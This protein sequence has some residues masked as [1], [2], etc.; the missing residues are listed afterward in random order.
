MTAEEII[1]GALE[2]GDVGRWD[3]RFP[4]NWRKWI[5]DDA[6]RRIAEALREAGLL[7]PANPAPGVPRR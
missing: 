3:G 1:V 6:P 5:G 4:S 2:R 7:S